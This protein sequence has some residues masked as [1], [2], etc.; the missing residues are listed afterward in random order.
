MSCSFHYQSHLARKMLTKHD[1]VI[2]ER[3]F[4]MSMIP[5]AAVDRFPILERI[6]GSSR[7]GEFKK[8]K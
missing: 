8:S 3:K 6:T 2:C 7:D 5:D 1:R 4:L